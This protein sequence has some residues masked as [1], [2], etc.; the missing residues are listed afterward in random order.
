MLGNY[1][2]SWAGYIEGVSKSN[3]N[4]ANDFISVHSDITWL[5]VNWRDNQ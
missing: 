5:P 1:I 4:N 2:I 3:I